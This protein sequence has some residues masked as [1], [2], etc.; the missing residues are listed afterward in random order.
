MNTKLRNT[1]RWSESSFGGTTGPSPLELSELKEQLDECNASR[2]RLFRLRTAVEAV[3]P[4]VASRVV[5]ALAF[6]LLCAAAAAVL[7]S[8]W[9][10]W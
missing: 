6:L 10:F 8:A 1:P 2:G 3:R 7:R 4:F 5:T 9:R